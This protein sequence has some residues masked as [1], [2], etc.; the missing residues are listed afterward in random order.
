MRNC[1]EGEHG[2]ILRQPFII[3]IA[4]AKVIIIAGK[5]QQIFRNINID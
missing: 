1:Q 5:L 3:L 4:D 2:A